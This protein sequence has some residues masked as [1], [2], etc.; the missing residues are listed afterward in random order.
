MLDTKGKLTQFSFSMTNV[1]TNAKC[2]AL[3]CFKP[4]TLYR[5]ISIAGKKKKRLWI[6][7]CSFINEAPGWDQAGAHLFLLSRQRALH[8]HHLVLFVLQAA[9]ELPEVADGRWRGVPAQQLPGVWCWAAR[10]QKQQAQTPILLLLQAH[11]RAAVTCG[12][13]QG[14]QQ[15]C[16]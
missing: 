8:S 1:K 3:T 16:L 12:R 13:T 9:G 6:S 5:N 15:H 7:L 14:F 10:I 2:P 4:H 11:Y